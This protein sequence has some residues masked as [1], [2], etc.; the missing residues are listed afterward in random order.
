MPRKTPLEG[1]IIVFK[2]CAILAGVF[3]FFFWF[4]RAIDFIWSKVERARAKY[5]R[6]KES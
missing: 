1:V 4:F 5:S 3:I 2:A 6:V